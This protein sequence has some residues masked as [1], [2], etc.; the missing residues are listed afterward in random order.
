MIDIAPY[1]RPASGDASQATMVAAAP[2]NFVNQDLLKVLRLAPM[3]RQSQ[4]RKEAT[5]NAA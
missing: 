1:I 2:G 5:S 4:E 3:K